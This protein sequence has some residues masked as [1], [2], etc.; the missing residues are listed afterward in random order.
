MTFEEKLSLITRNTEEVINTEEL[1]KIFNEHTHPKAYVGLEISGFLHLGTGIILPKKLNDLH[2]AGFE[3][4]V[5]LADWHSMI[6]NKLGGDLNAI[7]EIGREYFQD[8]LKIAGLGG[9]KRIKF[10]WSSELTND[11]NYRKTTD[12]S[13]HSS[14]FCNLNYFFPIV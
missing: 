10:L 3:V 13:L 4:I 9:K 14:T 11:S 7:Q 5:F 6:N 8:A 12:H 1:E 2:D